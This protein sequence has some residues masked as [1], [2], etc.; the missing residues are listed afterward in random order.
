MVDFWGW[1][2]I[3]ATFS[4]PIA[5]AVIGIGI[6]ILQELR[7]QKTG[8]TRTTQDLK[9]LNVFLRRITLSQI[10]EKIAILHD[11]PTQIPDWKTDSIFRY[12]IDRL[13]SD[14]RAIQEVRMLLTDTQKEKILVIKQEISNAVGIKQ[15]FL[16]RMNA[17]FDII[18][19]TTPPT[20]NRE[21]NHLEEL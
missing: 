8:F 13:I 6:F 7:G 10:Q 19:S 11:Y 4:L 20:L 17:A 9:Q 15:E 14:I 16:S 12:K 3:A 5:A 21:S 2:G 18:F 1:I